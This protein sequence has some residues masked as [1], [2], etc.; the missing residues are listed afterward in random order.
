MLEI[1]PRS[2]VG[3]LVVHFSGKVTGQEYQQFLDA[4]AERFGAGGQVNLVVEL[5]RPVNGH[6]HKAE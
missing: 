2:T 6:L 4:L 5:M 1:L 3:C